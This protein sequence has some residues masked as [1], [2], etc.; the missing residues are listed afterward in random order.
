MAAAENFADDALRSWRPIEGPQTRFLKSPAFEVMYGGAAGGGKTDG[1]LAGAVRF[2]RYPTYR[3]ILFRRTYPD[4]QKSLVDRSHQ[5]YPQSGAVY[6]ASDKV[7]K[8]PTG[9]KIWLAALDRDADVRKYQGPSF[10]FV[11]FDEL[12]Q[13]TRYQY[14]YMISRLRSAHG[15]PTRL[16]SAT[17]PGGEGHD[18][19]LERFAPWLY[20]LDFDDYKGER[21]LPGQVLYFR[22]RRGRDVEEYCNPEDKRGRTRTFIPA[23]VRDN[24]FYAGTE[25]EDNLDLL[26]RLQREQLKHGNWL[27]RAAAGVLFKRGWFEV[28][29]A[30]PSDV[31]ARVRYWDR[32]ATDS[33]KA[34]WTAGVLLSVTAYGTFF[35]EDVVRFQGRPGYVEAMIRQVAK[36]DLERYGTIDPYSVALFG[37]HDPGQAGKFEAEYYTRELAA[38][39]MQ[40][41]PPQGDKITRA[42]VCSVQ[43]EAHNVKLVRGKW[44]E[45]FLTE[46]EDFPEGHDDQIDAWSGAMRQVI[47]RAAF[48]KAAGGAKVHIV[49]PDDD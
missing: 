14:V 11:G 44:N 39:A 8:W 20:P 13:F 17:N 28:V 49:T 36:L 32:A 42:R 16:R 22:K 18:W 25:Y 15:I 27:A 37:E 12:T 9:A 31:V 41:I 40:M 3:G 30:A 26:D 23:S 43:S 38:Y 35:I 45:E 4:L 10:Q 6:N 46:A 33:E 2:V 1:L 24:P 7:W 5:I 48:F 19:V 21:A 34:D 47:H 29:D